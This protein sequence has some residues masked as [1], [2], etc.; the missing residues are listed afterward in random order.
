MGASVGLRR[1]NEGG[2]WR[3]VEVSVRRLG[4]TRGRWMGI[5]VGIRRAVEVRQL[6]GGWELSGLCPSRSQRR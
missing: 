4:S 1:V 6:T 2:Q 5:T 3:P